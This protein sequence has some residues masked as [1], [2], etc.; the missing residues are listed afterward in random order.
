MQK[1]QKWSHFIRIFFQIIFIAVPIAALIFGFAEWIF[2][3]AGLP[4][5][6]N[7]AISLSNL[8]HPPVTT[9]TPYFTR[10]ICFMLSLIP[11]SIT[12]FGFYH[13]IRLFK[14]YE[15]GQIFTIDNIRH[16]KICAYSVL[17]WFIADFI[18]HTLTVL[19]LT[20]NNPVGQITLSINFSFTHFSTLVISIIAI[21]IAQVMDEARKIKDE[22]DFII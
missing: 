15:L 14:L 4:S 10:I 12:M 2:P 1:I 3:D 6:N 8:N 19:A 18:I 5:T 17:S 20:I 7:I 16:I 22:N 9:S 21:I 13:L 11:S